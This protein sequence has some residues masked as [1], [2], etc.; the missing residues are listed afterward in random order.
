MALGGLH[1]PL[2]LATLGV[3]SPQQHIHGSSCFYDG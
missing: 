3:E 1:L 2:Q